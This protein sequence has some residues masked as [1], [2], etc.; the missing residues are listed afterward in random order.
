MVDIYRRRFET[1]G[2]GRADQAIVGLGGQ[3]YVADSE[4]QAKKEFRP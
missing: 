3:V 4:E 1:Y 2:H